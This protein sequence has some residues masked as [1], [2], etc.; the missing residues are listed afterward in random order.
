MPGH[1]KKKKGTNKKKTHAS[2]VF[3]RPRGRAAGRSAPP[4][5]CL[6]WR[7]RCPAPRPE[8]SL[9]GHGGE[10]PWIHKAV[11][12]DKR[13]LNRLLE[14]SQGGKDTWDHE[15]KRNQKI[16]LKK[17]NNKQLGKDNW[18]PKC[19]LGQLNGRHPRTSPFLGSVAPFGKW[20]PVLVQLVSCVRAYMHSPRLKR[21]HVILFCIL[22]GT[23]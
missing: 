9:S 6:A 22:Q 16:T 18:H 2:A 11:G 7:S 1:A 21:I 17:P 23:L 8:M 15:N 13:G 4:W 20:S 5:P 3:R 19:F 10:C 12:D 14:E